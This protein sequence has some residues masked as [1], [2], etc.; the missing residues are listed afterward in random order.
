M[1]KNIDFRFFSDSFELIKAKDEAGNEVMRIGGIA[2]TPDLDSQNEMLLLEGMDVSRAVGA[3]CN[4]N[5]QSMKDP[6]SIIGIISKAEKRMGK[7][8]YLE[9]DL[10][11]EH[12]KSKDVYNLTK[13][14]AKAN[15][16]QKMAFSIEGRAISR[17][18]LDPRKVTKSIIS[19]V[20]LTASPINR[21][22][23]AQ[24]IKGET[25][26]L[27]EPEFEKSES[28]YIIDFTDEK[29]NRITVDEN[30]NIEKAMTT[31]S[32]KPLRPESL[33]KKEKNLEY[34]GDDEEK[35]VKKSFFINEEN[36]NF[37]TYLEKSQVY[38]YF[39]KSIPDLSV[40]NAKR[41]YVTIEALQKSNGDT[42]SELNTDKLEKAFAIL[43]KIADQ[44]EDIS[45]G[46]DKEEPKDESKMGEEY[47]KEFSKKDDKDEMKKG[48]ESVDDELVKAEALVA[49]L[50]AKKESEL[51]KSEVVEEVKKESNVD[52]LFKAF[53]DRFNQ[54][55]EAL[56][57]V[58]QKANEDNELLKSEIL[59]KEDE[60]KATKEELQKS[61]AKLQESNKPK[62]ITSTSYIQK[63]EVSDSTNAMVIDANTPE[64]RQ[65]IVSKGDTLINWTAIEEGNVM[66]KSF[67]QHIDN[68]SYGTGGITP[69][70][71]T[72]FAQ[73]GYT[74]KS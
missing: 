41:L 22:T 28:K 20:A 74:I 40:E 14:L 54:K 8:L 60:V 70:I 12:Q 29:G 61:E 23:F 43:N 56:G 42:M 46:E 72:K 73:V 57:V 67:A 45:K 9:C 26:G 10:F 13:M 64:G 52:E 44:S 2:S 25:D 1:N 36:D 50:K 63:G 71:V 53:E 5:H 62:S 49:E 24:I 48:E 31:E 27:E 17:D 6:S 33:D 15:T 18:E 11:Q 4:W 3:T 47:E 65:A 66:E 30:Y 69:E 38:D 35:K 37:T 16:K 58:L 19:G 7:G 51:Q 34:D 55:F 59:K 39:F 32:G 68:L 21:S